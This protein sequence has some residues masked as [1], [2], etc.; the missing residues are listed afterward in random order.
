MVNLQQKRMKSSSNIITGQYVCLH[1][2]PASVADRIVATVI[3]GLV[4]VAYTFLMTMAYIFL[5]DYLHYVG[6]PS[7]FL[8]IVIYIPVLLY[9]PLC[10]YFFRGQSIG[11][12]LRHTRVISADGARPTIGQL[13]LR[14]MFLFVDL[15]MSGIGILPVLLT[16]RHQRFG[17]MA[18]G[19]M[20]IHEGDYKQWHASLDDFYA[21]TPS[22]HPTYP[23]ASQLS[24]N[25]ARLIERVL[26]ADS[27]YDAEQT[28]LLAQKVA[29]FLKV[30]PKTDDNIVFL[31][32]ILHDYQYFT[33]MP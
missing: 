11:K 3:D 25:Q 30:K 24:D 26:K 15:L 21:Q 17:D 6:L 23:Q 19:T 31:S 28:Q 22:Y 4:V 7:L 5:E 1:E 18:A 16:D 9:F 20:V 12:A 2:V 29:T 27:G 32:K 33:T 10:E 8:F 14:W 13:L